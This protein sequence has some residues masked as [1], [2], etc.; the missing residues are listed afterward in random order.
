MKS[1]CIRHPERSPMCLLR[2][3][4]LELCSGNYC[5]AMLL[6]NFEYWHNFK[7]DQCEQ[8]LALAREDPE[9]KPDLSLWFYK[10]A[11][12]L[13]ADLFGL[14]GRKAI[15]D[16]V[17]FLIAC[18]FV[19]AKEDSRN[20]MNRTRYFRLKPEVINE[21]VGTFTE[22]SK[23]NSRQFKK[24]PSAKSAKKTRSK[25]QRNTLDGSAM[26]SLPYTEITPQRL[27]SSSSSSSSGIPKEEEEDLTPLS[28]RLAQ[29]VVATPA[30]VKEI[31]E[32]ARDVDPSLN[33]TE[34]ALAAS[35][36]VPPG[37][38]VKFW[39]YFVTAVP[40]AIQSTR[41]I[42]ELQRMRISRAEDAAQQDHERRDRFGLIERLLAVRNPTDED[43]DL[44]AD[45]ERNYPTEIE[46]VRQR[47]T[48]KATA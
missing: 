27:Q 26:N 13:Q 25:V 37:H 24:A 20:S 46:E 45:I 2:R 7:L 29:F 22:S 3:H 17:T 36:A 10:S 48:L 47:L 1:S 44:L 28:E 12:D 9:Y 40:N 18:G 38:T 16:A 6:A 31:F 14:F 41:Y 30:Q 8:E 4:Y 35:I 15:L 5:A 33:A 23:L 19:E 21:K 32:R 43:R 34:I 11:A 42:Q 39:K